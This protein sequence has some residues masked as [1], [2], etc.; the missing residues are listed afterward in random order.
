MTGFTKSG[1]AVTT[2]A[3][4]VLVTAV[5]AQPARRGP[6]PDGPPLPANSAMVNPY[7]MLPNWP[8][9]GDIKP[10][11]AIGNIFQDFVVRKLTPP[12]QGKL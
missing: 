7:K 8:H 6:P 3:L 1:I 10:G 5:S 9:L 11:A 2:A 12:A 4:C